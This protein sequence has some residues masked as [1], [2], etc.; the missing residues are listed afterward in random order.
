MHASVDPQSDGPVRAWA[1]EFVER[2]VVPAA[3]ELDRQL[4]PADCFSWDVLDAAEEIGLL[5]L[6]ASGE[7][8]GAGFDAA[9][10]AVVIEELARGDLGVALLVAQNLQLI[11]LLR[12][13]ATSAQL[14]RWVR[15]VCE[16]RR[17][18]LSLAL[19][20]VDN[21]VD[22][23][24]ILDDA[25]DPLR[26]TADRRDGGWVLNG[27]KD[28]VL[29]GSLA[30]LFLVFAQT[31]PPGGLT[32]GVTCFIVERETPG[33]DVGPPHDKMGCRFAPSTEF[34]L[35]DCFV[36]DENV[37]GR[38]HGGFDLLAQLFPFSHAYAAAGL[39]G[40]S[41]TA[42]DRALKWAETRVQ[43]GQPIILHEAVATHLGEIRGL[44]EQMR[45]YAARAAQV[46]GGA[47]ELEP[48]CAIPEL[49]LAA[50]VWRV[51]YSSMEIHGGWAYMK[52]LGFDKL[53]RDGV[54]GAAVPP[55]VRVENG[56]ERV[57]Q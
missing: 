43:G 37:L 27:R 48:P 6:T 26:T 40:I 2:T 12:V 1:A 22:C 38:L 36:P 20:E 15:L 11:D 3:A 47:L 39:L 16:E 5:T 34:V 7:M 46:A 31:D 51:V 35:R 53:V 19:A 9:A 52:E 42:S 32:S 45:G 17:A 57:S 44:V 56:S 23:L 41:R 28:L 55:R 49:T 21:S 18:V 25:A 30:R 13:A 24:L 50:L 10:A 4:H 29:G 33:L 54:A 8:G 14:E